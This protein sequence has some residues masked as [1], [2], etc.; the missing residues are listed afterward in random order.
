[1][2]DQSESRGA[3][4]LTVAWMLACTSTVVGLAVVISLRLLMLVAPAA[5][6][7]EHPLARIAG[8]L[9]FVALVTGT[10]CLA[11]TP[12]AYR[13]RQARPPRAITIA[14]VVIGLLPWI[15]LAVLAFP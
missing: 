6:G 13:V 1:M 11:M 3:V 4:A 5:A 15:M 8:I 2:F 10:C 14:A 7:A 12:L 9:L